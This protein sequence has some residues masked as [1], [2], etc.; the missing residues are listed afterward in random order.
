M[1]AFHLMGARMPEYNHH[2]QIGD[3][4]MDLYVPP[5]DPLEMVGSAA[6]HELALTNPSLYGLSEMP[7]FTSV[8]EP[9]SRSATTYW[10]PDA[11]RLPERVRSHPFPSTF[12]GVNPLPYNLVIPRD[13]SP[14]GW[15]A[16]DRPALEQ[17]PSAGESSQS[18]LTSE[19]RPEIE[20]AS[21]RSP[22]SWEDWRPAARFDFLGGCS[23]SF[24]AYESPKAA[25]IALCD[26]EPFQ[27]PDAEQF[28]EKLTPEMSIKQQYD[29]EPA[30]LPPWYR[31]TGSS[32]G[33]PDEHT[34]D[35]S[36]LDEDDDRIMAHDVGE[37]DVSDYTPK[38]PPKRSPRRGPSL[39][40]TTSPHSSKRPARSRNP[41]ALPTKSTTKIT[42]RMSAPKTLAPTPSAP[43]LT[44]SKRG[45]VS[46]PQCPQCSGIYTSE[47]ALHKHTLASHT[48]PFICTFRRYGCPSTFG[49]KNEWKRHVSSQHLRL[50]IYRC[51]MEK[52]VP[53]GSKPSHRRKSST[54]SH[55]DGRSAV[56]KAG[57]Y[58]DFNRK[59]LFT[60]HVRRMHGA[61]IAASG[62]GMDASE[63]M[64]EE[65]QKRCWMKLRETPPASVCG[66]CPHLTAVPSPTGDADPDR[67]PPSAWEGP[68][69]WDYRMEH[70]GRHLEKGEG[71]GK[72]DEDEGLREWMVRE[73]LLTPARA[74][75]W[76]VVGCG[77]RKRG[78][79]AGA[80]VRGRLGIGS[81]KGTKG[82]TGPAPGPE[83]DE[84]MD[85]D[86]DSDEMDHA[87]N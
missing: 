50:G 27:D 76:V 7:R 51:D 25:G 36:M 13:T 45:S 59:D 28:A 30:T 42:K 47:S 2:G 23:P 74:G 1:G 75:G 41:T 85:G 14:D 79:G 5:F 3:D 55:V 32:I 64:L 44:S 49:S 31:P 52:C 72:E 34:G 12:D 22:P 48:R 19:G 40:A 82:N 67:S 54:A 83:T 37:E 61:A 71:G 8:H 35:S 18:A 17:N 78:K 46:C 87:A 73:G 43:R 24:R 56:G 39:S 4:E 26:I 33:S 6:H 53:Q 11:P 20:L 57:S 65:I 9:C 69:S 63:E 81:T 29:V 10:A 84:D 16:S 15:W 70:V 66:I 38:A 77:G 80:E 86:G 60:Q 21:F 58:N 68:G 62:N